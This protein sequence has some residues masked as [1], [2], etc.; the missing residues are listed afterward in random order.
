[1]RIVISSAPKAGNKWLKCLL[2]SIYE[3]EWLLGER[4]GRAA[5]GRFRDR[6]AA[7]GFPDGS[8][9]HQHRRYSERL[10]DAIEAMPAHPVTIVRNPYDLFVSYYFWAQEKA[11]DN[12]RKERQRPRD[13]LVGRPI[14]HP[15]ALTFL[16]EEFGHV[17]ILSTGW[18][19]SGRATVVRYE[20]LHADPVGALTRVTNQIQ[21]VERERIE[22]AL[23]HCSV[24]N[25]RQMSTN[26]ARHVRKGVVGDSHNHL[27]DA[28]LAIFRARHADAIRA[29]GYEVR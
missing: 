19:Q 10:V 2:G 26:L 22:Q 24:E 15:E 9:M 11:A 28:H 7:G 8:I 3:L 4:T 27:T 20:E 21:S 17:L 14:D 5:G 13:V 12:E 16:D 1:M 25:M 23:E 6:F 29:L 18:L